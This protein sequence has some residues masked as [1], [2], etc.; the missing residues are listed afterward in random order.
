MI[1][2]S[3]TPEVRRGFG[4][5]F[6]EA[7]SKLDALQHAMGSVL[8]SMPG[9]PVAKYFDIAMGV[10][11]H[12][13][14][15]PPSPLLPVPQMGMVFDIMGAMMNCISTVVPK[16]EAPKV[17]EVD[18][19]QVVQEAPITVSNICK[20]L[21]HSMKPSVQVHGQW[22]AN[23]GTSIQHLPGVFLHTSPVIKPMASSEMWMGS[24]TVL[25]DGGP[26]S[27][28]FHP[29]LS[30]NLVGMPAPIRALKPSKPKV[31]LM[32]PT[33]ML[34]T[35][36]SVGKPVWVGGPPIID[37]FQ[38][39][40]QLGLKGMGKLWK[41][42]GDKF[43]GLID[44]IKSKNPKLGA[45][46]QPVK[47]RLFG[48]PVDAAT[49]RVYSTNTDIE[50]NGVLPFLWERTYYSDAQVKGAL[51]YNWHHSYEMGL[52]D[53]G[54]GYA[55]LRLSDGRETVVPLVALAEE[56]YDRKEQHTFTRDALGYL[57]IDA[58]GLR[59]RF[60]GTKNREGFQML[61]EIATAEGFNIRFAY[62]HKGDLERITDSR[63]QVLHVENTPEGFISKIY[64]LTEKEQVIDLI[65]YRYDKAGNLAWV[66][67]VLGGEKQFFYK[68]H[69]LVKLI[70]QTGQC[71]YW[72]Y[73]GKGDG[74]DAKCVHT[75]GSAGVLEYHT[76]YLPGHTIT[77]N[78]YGATT[79]Y[80]YDQKHLIYKII[81]ENGGV[82]H[83]V[84]NA[85]EEIELITD[86]EGLTQKYTY[87]DYG[88][89]LSVENTNGQ[90]AFYKY[91]QAQNLIEATSFAGKKVGFKYDH[92][93][94]I[95]EKTFADGSTMLYTYED[96]H[97]KSI[98]DSKGNSYYLHFDKR[99]QLIQLLYPN[100]TFHQWRY[101]DLGNVISE[102]DA[103]GNY[104]YYQYD[105]AGN[106]IL[107]KEPDGNTH[108][109]EYDTSYNLIAARDEQ[110]QVFLGYGPLGVLTSRTQ[111]GRTVRFKYNKEL[112]LTSIINEAGETYRFEL[113]PMGNV[114][115]EEGFDG[116]I[117]R[118][119]RDQNAR[120]TKILRPENKW[121]SFA[122]DGVGNLIEEQHSDGSWSA[123]KYD[124]DGL[125]IAA[126]NP[127]V[128][129]KLTRNALG[130]IVQETQNEHQVN[131]KYNQYGE[132]I[133]LES[134]LGA[135]VDLSYTPMG[136]LASME[137][138]G[139]QSRI[140]Y[141]ATGLEI[142]REL[143][144][145]VQ[146]HTH[147]DGYGRVNHQSVKT[148]NI[149][150]SR[151]RYNWSQGNQLK[152]LINELTGNRVDF[153]YD[154]WDNLVSAEYSHRK[155]LTT[156]YKCPDAIGN[157]FETPQQK[158]RKY[159]S[160][161]LQ[162]DGKWYYYYDGE[163]N[164]IQKSPN[165]WYDRKKPQEWHTGCWQYEWNANGSLQSVTRPDGRTIA[166][167][168]DA[169]G[170]RISKRYR[171]RET[172]FVWSGNVPL[173][174]LHQEDNTTQ[175]VITW[176]FEGFVP[177]AKIVDEQKYSIVSDYLGKPFQA[178]DSEGELVWAAEHNIY[179]K[180]KT[181]K[182]DKTF[183][184]FRQLGQY[185]DIEID[186]YYNRF[187]YYDCHTGTY[188]SQDPIGLLGGMVFYGYVQ[189]VNSW[190]DVF[191]LAGG[192]IG[193]TVTIIAKTNVGTT[194]VTSSS[195]N[196]AHAEINGLKRL[197]E[198][199]ALEGADVY[200]KDVKGHFIN[201]IDKDVQVCANCRHNMFQIL[202]KGGANSVTIPRL[203][204]E[205]ITIQRKDFEK[206]QNATGEVLKEYEGTRL[207]KKRSD[208]SFNAL[209]N[210]KHHH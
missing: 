36:T 115:S 33:S 137:A 208:A 77:R 171:N 10:D 69:L 154:A 109:F 9:L 132:L 191:G 122:Y 105:K 4:A 58:T 139:W 94:R 24:S 201:G 78:S 111:N 128:N 164:L 157:L 204:G 110:H 134:S 135:A 52:Y 108:H 97:L 26:C 163:G 183:I 89:L 126:L 182:G 102:R 35:I 39:A 140:E 149:E 188:I 167:K 72:E 197:K 54:N 50:L 95:V 148:R 209:E 90:K 57:L 133:H 8:P 187:R 17:V 179:G 75:W 143:S 92:W 196:S 170:R 68:G 19:E 203:G 172:L 184:P 125:L 15:A 43:Q 185:E 29:A 66:K 27:T 88:K 44:R 85:F 99:H 28:Q 130:Q 103:K 83:Q 59:Y 147:R 161:Q 91:D 129:T 76:Q 32:A 192:M 127:D 61:S 84:Y 37:L 159:K 117:R 41:K 51:G 158:D 202:I 62:N 3:S 16:P 124:N 79:H 64:T 155:E 205:A 181:L 71:F 96:E 194:I 104:T 116:I 173:H 5:M 112:Q 168:Y 40:M 193:A 141:D 175:E 20:M 123:F 169:L 86:P 156:V 142:Q 138:N 189:D 153:E 174:E 13:S 162:Y 100:E 34:L 145:G 82:T 107:L 38:L 98:T 11:F 118:Y 206:V 119:E 48:E 210:K 131:Y 74:D 73:E 45:I 93:H 2:K 21:V 46:L 180:V 199:E 207:F 120:V 190:V 113:D 106:V 144:G 55:T 177:V 101:D 165:Q 25:M 12:E 198:L 65:Q 186:L 30:C 53:M 195:G 200:I 176:L 6:E 87:N 81:D 136:Q 42:V 22:V 80:F 160:S 151:K 7:K 60:N 56:Y 70:N 178:Y 18:G 31:S 121:T 47:C 23:A 49:G 67:D 146:V 114:L 152:S 14:I 166:F 150:Q 63:G 1:L